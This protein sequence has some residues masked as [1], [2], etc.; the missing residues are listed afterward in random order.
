MNTENGKFCPLINKDCVQNK[1]MFYDAESTFGPLCAVKS[2]A[3]YM[4]QMV[5]GE[6]EDYMDE[7]EDILGS[8]GDIFEEPDEDI[9]EPE[10][11]PQS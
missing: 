3:K 11:N 2:T 4:K 8:E 9:E 1:C 5:T 10:D 7:D 6:D